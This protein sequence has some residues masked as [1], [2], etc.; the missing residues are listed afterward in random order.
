MVFWESGRIQIWLGNLLCALAVMCIAL[1]TEQAALM[2]GVTPTGEAYSV[3]YRQLLT[4][5]IGWLIYH[6]TLWPLCVPTP[7]GGCQ[8]ML[9]DLAHRGEMLC[10]ANRWAILILHQ[11]Q[12]SGR[13]LLRCLVE[14]VDTY[15]GYCSKMLSLID[16]AFP[17]CL[18]PKGLNFHWDLKSEKGRQSLRFAPSTSHLVSC[19]D[20]YSPVTKT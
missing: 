9:I 8:L 14:N 1:S 7:V 16:S 4:H 17:C 15:G 20:S 3:S 19:D 5:G 2:A 11:W 6:W 12:S 18:L 13:N 10:V